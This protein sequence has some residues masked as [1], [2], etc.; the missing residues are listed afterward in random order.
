[1]NQL[2][3]REFLQ[4]ASV[5]TASIA[6]GSPKRLKAAD[7]GARPFCLNYI[8]ASPMYGTTPLAEVLPEVAKVGADAIDIWPR[9]HAN[10]RE[11][12]EELGLE[13]FLQLLSEQSVQLGVITRFDLG[14][15]A[16]QYELRVLQRLG[17]RLLVTGAGRGTGDS[18]QQRVRSFVE[19]MKPHVAVAA[20]LGLVIAIENHANSLIDT[21]DS[22]RYFAEAAPEKHL[23]IA[24]APYHLP[25]DEE[26]LAK[27][28]ED[29]GPRL[30]LFY[31]WQHGAGCMTAQPKDQEMLQMPGRGPLDFTPLLAALR[32]TGYAGWTEIFMH[33]FPRGIPILE[34]TAAVTDAINESRRYLDACLAKLASA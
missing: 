33:P 4:A 12:V 32:K 11:Q 21:P 25:Q 28:I 17:G 9:R 29:L 3:R 1:M 31:A 26:L 5:A 6:I 8:L 19:S 34:S 27:L 16:L 13:R 23:G 7:D 2:H 30:A 20:E 14:P 22:I 15:Y 18:V 24:L 10:H